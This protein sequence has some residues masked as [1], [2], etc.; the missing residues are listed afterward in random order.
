MKNGKGRQHHTHTSTTYIDQ[1][2]KHTKKNRTEREI[3]VKNV[4]PDT[5][6]TQMYNR[7]KKSRARCFFRLK[8]LLLQPLRLD[9]VCSI[10]Y[11]SINIYKFNNSI[12]FNGKLP[13][14]NVRIVSARNEKDCDRNG[15]NERKRNREWVNEIK[16]KKNSHE[17]RRRGCFQ[18]HTIQST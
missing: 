14:S 17:L 12:L 8:L 9:G 4:A 11:V 15:D 1:E 5:L 2:V 3:M 13:L 6:Y 16:A 10:L 7:K 18:A